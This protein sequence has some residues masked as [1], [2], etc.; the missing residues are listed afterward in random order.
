MK[1]L[2][3]LLPLLVIVCLAWLALSWKNAPSEVRFTT[4]KTEDLV[5]TLNT[6]GKV[7]PLSWA[8]VRA[9]R[10]GRLGEIRVQKGTPV[11]AG[12]IIALMENDELRASLQAAEARVT[13][14]EGDQQTLKQGGSSSAI[15]EIDANLS[16]L[17]V[18]KNNAEQE[19]AATERLVTKKAATPQE[20]TVLRGRVNI[21]NEQIRGLQ[22]RK[23]ALVSP[24]DRTSANGRL[25]EAQA[26]VALAKEKLEQGSLTSP[27]DGVVFQIDLRPGA[28][29]NPGDL[30]A[31]VGRVDSMRVN[32]Y[33]DEP[34]L[35][36][37]ATGQPVVVTWD[38][39]PGK[40][41]VG[42]VEK[43]PVQIVSLGNR[44]VGEV[45]LTIANPGADLPPGANINAA[46]R[47]RTAPKATTIPKETLRRE[48]DISGVFR[49]EEGNKV[50]WVPVETGISNVSRIQIKSGLKPGDR[51][52]LATDVPLRNGAV[53]KAA[54]E[55]AQ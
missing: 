32:V 52:A 21:L 6:N 48:G 8:S 30:V 53:V 36:R 42:T 38:A 13:Q 26:A 44:Q 28:Y 55:D 29:L 39:R 19:L 31:N 35:G 40:Q 25:R 51:V 4:V 1:M 37:V 43:M 7:E 11:S 16:R 3:W 24:G 27:I 22:E 54:A 2:Y 33:V 47:C 46:I 10:P 15:A 5:D 45:T 23:S 9:E 17:R 12:S 20:A 34:E 50:A 14:V 18:E 41:W 49:L